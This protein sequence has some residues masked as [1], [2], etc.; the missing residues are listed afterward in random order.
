MYS[1][2]LLYFCCIIC[3]AFAFVNVLDTNVIPIHYNLLLY[4]N[5]TS[6]ETQGIVKIDV[7]VNNPAINVIRI[8]S[9]K[10]GILGASLEGI[11]STS[12]KINDEQQFID[13][14]FP[15]DTI[16]PIKKL[17]KSK[18]V[19]EII[20]QGKLSD[21]MLGFYR[22]QYKDKNT[23]TSEIIATTHM[24][25]I[26]AR[27]AFPCFDEPKL[28]ATYSITLLSDPAYTHLS[29]M[30]V[31]E[32]F[33]M[34]NG[35]K[36][37]KFNRSPKMS[38][39]L[40]AFVVAKLEYIE[41]NNF[42]V[43]VRVYTIPGHKEEGKYAATLAAETLKFFENVLK[44]RYPLP[45]LDN[46]A[47]PEFSAGAME[48]WGL[49]TYRTSDLLLDK[50]SSTLKKIQRVTEV[51]QHEVAHQW[52]GNLVTMQE[53][54]Q[55]WLNEGFATWMSHFAMSK[56]YPFWNVEERS[57]SETLRAAFSLDMLASSHPIE[58]NIDNESDIQQIFDAIS[59]SKG[60]SLLK[61]I[62]DKIGETAFI[63]GISYYL[64]NNMYK[65]TNT[66]TLFKYL[67]F[68]ANEDISY[69]REWTTKPGFPLI[70]VV[71]NKDNII[72][73][74]SKFL[75]TTNTT[76]STNDILYPIPVQILTKDGERNITMKEQSMKI[77]L[78]LERFIKI[79]Y[80][81]SGF[82]VTKYSEERL[83]KLFSMINIL[84]V[85]DQL[86]LLNDI[87][88]LTVSGSLSTDK[89]INYL[90]YL[91]S[92][93]SYLIWEMIYKIVISVKEVYK[94]DYH[95]TNLL[96]KFVISMAAQ[97]FYFLGWEISKDDSQDV[98]QL[99]IIL[100]ILLNNANDP[101]IEVV[102]KELYLNYKANITAKIP[103]AYITTLFEQCGKR[104][105]IEDYEF[106]LKVYKDSDDLNIQQSALM[107][108]GYFK[109]SDLLH[110]TISMLLTDDV[111]KQDIHILM[112]GI[113]SSP[114]G[115]YQLWEWLKL[116]WV[117]ILKRYP[118]GSSSLG[119]IVKLCTIGFVSQEQ[120]SQIKYFFKDKSV[121]TYSKLLDQSLEM[122]IIK[123]TWRDRDFMRLSNYL[124]NTNN[125]H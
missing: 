58:V 106:L 53:W 65:T 47:I 29:N 15:S 102:S 12:I 115:T 79:N 66:S 51:I 43:P 27:R 4:A 98:K 119:S 81:G 19:L 122:I 125:I 25:P 42:R 50:N 82:Y 90:Q 70:S 38:S 69:I 2:H 95:I 10:L 56:F 14:E 40:V 57:I 110:K 48:N 72:L 107:S 1:L 23:N 108:L 32:S 8:N 11:K 5:M 17:L 123:S 44:I 22:A 121:I 7:I 91:K 28:K 16:S 92:S 86:S 97:K 59:Y 71:E 105:D 75:A 55:L 84:S 54:G 20:F 80:N 64:K 101:I 41:T 120:Y 77:E 26:Y 93:N 88:F 124:N 6:F 112:S 78:N 30:D 99:K 33:M 73:T 94:F 39:Y 46:I 111:L 13:I 117:D 103:K 85:S 74:Q 63:T 36:V 9:Y 83:N 96:D 118:V 67:S 87:Y 61:M 109:E 34:E 62:S 104:G 24:E 31:K 35:L 3:F 49:I 89:L 45:K 52:F 37:T 21:D 60:S 100:F 18:S 116:N 76:I 113:R 68:A 114:E